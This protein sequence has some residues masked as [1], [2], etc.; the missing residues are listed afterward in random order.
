MILFIVAACPLRSVV[1]SLLRNSRGNILHLL[2]PRSLEE[3][4]VLVR[5]DHTDRHCG[6]LGKLK[7]KKKIMVIY[8]MLQI[9]E[10]IVSNVHNSF[11][12][13]NTKFEVKITKRSHFGADPDPRRHISGYCQKI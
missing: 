6:G 2:L 4:E 12:R 8:K 13:P 11:I 7:F 9:L 5:G 3:F 10:R 1:F